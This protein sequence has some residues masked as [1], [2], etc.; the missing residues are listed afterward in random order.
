MGPDKSASASIHGVE[1][2]NLIAALEEAVHAGLPGI[3]CAIATKNG[4]IW[5]GCAGDADIHTGSPIEER[6]LF[7]IGS[8]T[9]VFMSVIALQLVEENRLDLGKTVGFYLDSGVTYGIANAASA[10]ISSLLSHTSGIASW[11][12]D[13]VWIREGR[14]RDI[15][16]PRIWGKTDTLEYICSKSAQE[17]QSIPDGPVPGKHSYSNTNF[18]F[19]G[20]VIEAITGNPAE[21]EI[22][23]RITKPLNLESIYLEGFEKSTPCPVPHR[24]QFITPEFRETD[25]VSPQFPLVKADLMDASKSNLSVEWVAGGM[26]SS[27]ADLAKFF[28]A[29]RD[30]MLLTPASMELMATWI[31]TGNQGLEI[32]HGLFRTDRKNGATIGHDGG[33]LGFTGFAWWAEDSD[34]V[35]TALSNV[36]AMHCGKAL[37]API[38]GRGDTFVDLAKAL[39]NRYNL[40]S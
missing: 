36:G 31:P 23:S 1:E 22:R 28:L 30:G 18:T 15:D 13:P 4:V 6:H 26:L 8:I 19:L 10:T 2:A 17:E 32:S 39:A 34:C 11:E 16:P 25:G 20:L 5:Q 29:I 37:P 33:V 9:K 35:V 7:G 27:S 3:S 40:A 38:I 12:D 14:G 21:A 24:Y